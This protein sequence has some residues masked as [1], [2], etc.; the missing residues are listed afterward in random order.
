[1]NTMKSIIDILCTD[2][3]VHPDIQRVLNTRH[4]KQEA[5]KLLAEPEA[6]TGFDDPR[7]FDQRARDEADHFTEMQDADRRLEP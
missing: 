6:V 4:T 2:P 3:G 1:M 5:R 7:T